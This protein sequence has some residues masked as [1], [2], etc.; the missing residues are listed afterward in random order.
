MLL[1]DLSEI[2]TSWTNARRPIGERAR[3]PSGYP[4]S[5]QTARHGRSARHVSASD[6]TP[7]RKTKECLLS[8]E[9]RTGARRPRLVLAALLA[10]TLAVLL[11]ATGA[12]AAGHHATPKPTV[13]LVHGAWAD[14][15]SW[16]AVGDRLR[17]AGYPVR[18]PP[19]PLRNL[20]TDGQTI[21]DFL[22][23]LSGPIILVGHSYGGAVITQAATGNPNVK[24][25]VYEDAFAPDQG[26]QIFPLAG[27]DSALNV[28]PATVFDFV[29]YP[30]APA[31]DVDLYLKQET[32][33]GPFA[34]GLPQPKALS[35]YAAQRPLALSA[36]FTPAGVPAWKTIPSWYVLGTQDQIITPEAQRFMA[37]RAGSRITEVRAGHLALIT[38]ADVVA[39]VIGQAAAATV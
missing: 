2:D 13:V 33:L 1:I 23:T 32:F 14:G 25:L 10:V 21:A 6:T 24:A 27:A 28:D 8:E 17:R 29:P 31:G 30:G 26:E 38:K 15:S 5:R 37:E 19:N 34:A 4:L 22:A 9:H 20:T 7:T 16:T 11:P 39:K 35:L 18:I 36:G 3:T 12:A